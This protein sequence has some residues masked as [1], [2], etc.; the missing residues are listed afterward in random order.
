MIEKCEL[1]GDTR[2]SDASDIESVLCVLVCVVCERRVCE[3]CRV[4]DTP[5]VCKE[6]GEGGD[7]PNDVSL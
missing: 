5:P 4:S 2:I 6:C 3:K 1:C 7:A